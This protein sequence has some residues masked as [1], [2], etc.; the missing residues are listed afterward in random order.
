LG[1][2]Q[3]RFVPRRLEDGNKKTQVLIHTC[4]SNYTRDYRAQ[5]CRTQDHQR[6]TFH[7]TSSHA[8]SISH[9]HT[10]KQFASSVRHYG[11]QEEF[12]STL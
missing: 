2:I 4:I 6:K 9:H 10:Q 3:I 8:F 11:S 12:V 5:A 7:R 1:R